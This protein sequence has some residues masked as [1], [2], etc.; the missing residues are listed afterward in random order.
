[1]TI[2]AQ[3]SSNPQYPPESPERRT[4]GID[5]SIAPPSDAFAHLDHASLR[6]AVARPLAPPGRYLA[7]RDDGD[8]LLIRLDRPI[9]R[10]GRGLWADIRIEDARVSRRH[11]IIA[12]RGD[13]V[14]LLD[15]RSANGTFVNGDQVTIAYLNDG[16]VVGFGAVSMRFAE[17][18]PACR[19]SRS[20]RIALGSVLAR[21]RLLGDARQP[22]VPT[23]AV[24][25][26]HDRHATTTRT[27]AMADAHDGHG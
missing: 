26:T 20:R 4:L 22:T 11:A 15:D 1:M 9:L 23:P 3:L 24:P 12:Q 19:R 5:A 25:H 17:I 18:E 8:E 14:R 2:Q 21:R 13:G 27:T 6:R 10:I 16:D 7:V